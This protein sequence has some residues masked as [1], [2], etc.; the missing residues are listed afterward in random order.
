[1]QE[2]VQP[3]HVRGGELFAVPASSSCPTQNDSTPESVP[4][5]CPSSRLKESGRRGMWVSSLWLPGANL[6]CRL[7]LQTLPGVPP[8]LGAWSSPWL[9][10]FQEEVLPSELEQMA[11]SP[12]PITSWEQKPRPG[13][14]GPPLLAA[15]AGRHGP[16]PKSPA[17]FS[18][19]QPQRD[20]NKAVV[21]EI[22]KGISEDS[23][24]ELVSVLSEIHSGSLWS[25]PTL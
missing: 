1:M 20:Q 25:L 19:A 3:R 8:G 5:S 21:A 9:S 23:K 2:G 14:R 12:T 24:M 13:P 22:P 11:W 10:P 16:A 6:A 17:P 18:A 7:S 4:C 15:G